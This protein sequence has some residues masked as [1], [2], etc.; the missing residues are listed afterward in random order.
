MKLPRR[1]AWDY[2]A[3]LR[4]LHFHSIECL[5]QRCFVPNVQASSRS[6]NLAHQTA[7][8]FSWSNLD[9]RLYSFSDEHSHGLVPFDGSRHLSEESVETALCI[10]DSGSIHIADYRD[11]RGLKLDGT[12]IVRKPVLGWLHE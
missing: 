6:V 11:A 8:H 3:L 9:E 12:Q 7:Q 2:V 4:R 10:F 1:V 5:L